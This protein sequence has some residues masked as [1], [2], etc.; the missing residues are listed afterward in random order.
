MRQ[1]TGAHVVATEG[2]APHGIAAAGHSRGGEGRGQVQ[3]QAPWGC[4]H[5]HAAADSLPPHP[6]RWREIPPGVKGGGNPR[7]ERNNPQSRGIKPLFPCF[8]RGVPPHRMLPVAAVKLWCTECCRFWEEGR[9]KALVPCSPHTQGACGSQV[10][11]LGRNP[12]S[13]AAPQQ[14]L[15]GAAVNTGYKNSSTPHGVHAQV[16]GAGQAG[17]AGH[18]QW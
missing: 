3:A 2:G 14:R 10:M 9:P 8:P 6:N 13:P 12:C 1:G 5:R 7:V 11:V 17:R 16:P 18:W 15:Q 4:S